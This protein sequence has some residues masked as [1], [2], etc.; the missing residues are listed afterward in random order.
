MLLAQIGE[1]LPDTGRAGLRLAGQVLMPGIERVLALPGE[2][3]GS[4]LQLAGLQ[5]NALPR[6]GHVGDAAADLLHGFQLALVGVVKDLPRIIRRPERGFQGDDQRRAQAFARIEDRQYRLA[7]EAGEFRLGAP[8]VT[9]PVADLAVHPE[10]VAHDASPS[11]QYLRV[12]RHCL[13]QG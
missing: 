7:D 13:R 6:G 1:L 2:P 5:L 10:P 12:L 11:S 4:L 9:E 8:E 3:G